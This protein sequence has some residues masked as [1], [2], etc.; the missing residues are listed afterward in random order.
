MYTLNYC[1]TCNVMLLEQVD[2]LAQMFGI[3]SDLAPART[4]LAAAAETFEAFRQLWQCASICEASIAFASA[5]QWPAVEP[6]VLED[7]ARDL[8]ARVRRV[9]A[10]EAASHAGVGLSAWVGQF[11]TAC[12]LAAAL[13][14]APMQARHWQMLLTECEKRRSAATASTVIASTAKASATAS[15]GAAAAGDR[16]DDSD[17]DSGHDQQKQQQ[18]QH[19]RPLVAEESD[20]WTLAMVLSLQLPAV[21]GTVYAV[22]ARA[23]LEHKH[24]ELLRQLEHT[25]SNIQFGSAVS[26]SAG[27]AVVEGQQ[28]MLLLQLSE[29]DK[30]TLESDLV[31][32]Q[33]MSLF[34][35]NY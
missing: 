5:L 22:L 12:P 3:S 15:T 32:V 7:I 16:G 18:Q 13:R 9:P 34:L 8:S 24:G 35:I 27:S 6:A 19:Q 33:V 29:V 11:T 1:I 21:A 20:S 28:S 14:R 23:G 4:H 25:W 31:T 30:E 17:D 26:E 10:A 2:A